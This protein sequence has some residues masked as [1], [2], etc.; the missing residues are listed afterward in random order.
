MDA[1]DDDQFFALKKIKKAASNE[2]SRN[3]YNLKSKV[4]IPLLDLPEIQ[5]PSNSSAEE[6]SDDSPMTSISS[7]EDFKEQSASAAKAKKGKKTQKNRK[8][9]GKLELPWSGETEQSTFD[10]KVTRSSS[11][12]IFSKADQ[13]ETADNQEHQ[14]S[15]QHQLRETPTFNKI[16]NW[17]EQRPFMQMAS[18]T[19]VSDNARRQRDATDEEVEQL[20]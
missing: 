18:L 3:R 7:N 4:H 2:D 17:D 15:Q 14:I 6:D 13:L 12:R 1:Q 8:K 16:M 11:S 10:R 19:P 5:A 20:P 9:K